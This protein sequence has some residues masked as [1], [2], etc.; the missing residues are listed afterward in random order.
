MKV[1]DQ[2]WGFIVSCLCCSVNSIDRECM[3]LDGAR[4]S[5]PENLL[6][7]TTLDCQLLQCSSTV[8]GK[9]VLVVGHFE[10]FLVPKVHVWSI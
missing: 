7:F 10:S 5:T 4:I 3:L 2:L 8:R 1:H 9:L 6:N